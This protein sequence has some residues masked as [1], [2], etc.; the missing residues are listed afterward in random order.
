VEVYQFGVLK[1]EPWYEL[2]NAGFRVTG[3]AGSDF[4]GNLTRFKPW[5][6]AIPLLGPERTL[7]RVE[8]DGTTSAYE[9]WAEGIRNGAVVVS[10][11]PLLNLTIDGR[12]PGQVLDWDGESTMVRA[13]AEAAFSR[14]LEVLELVVNG[15]V[16]SSSSGD[17]MRQS[18]TL[19]AEVPLRESAWIAARARGRRLEGEPERWAH[20]N[21]VYVLRARAPVHQPEARAAVLRRWLRDVVYYRSDALT[22]ARPEHRQELLDRIDQATHILERPPRPWR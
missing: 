2:L 3:I 5:P 18:L 4:P 16:V 7:V 1:T 11:G 12:G 6:R 22:F 14:P 20:T 8:E 15:R 21:P 13:V 10:N 19:T 9:H 17:A